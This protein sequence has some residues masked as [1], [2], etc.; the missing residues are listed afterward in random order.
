MATKIKNFKTQKNE[1][2]N[3][4]RDI[5]AALKAIGEKYDVT[6]L[7]GNASYNDDMVQFKLTCTTKGENGEVE[8]KEAKDFK[9]YASMYGLKPEMLGKEFQY[10]RDRFQI[11]G[12]KPRSQKC[13][14]VKMVGTDK[15]YKFEPEAVNQL[16][17]K[18]VT[19]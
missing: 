16:M 19:A 7:A 4:R 12:L 5:N 15:S 9:L 18:T 3:I 2:E 13:V 1:I 14:I 6:I 17:S 11:T 8:T 10:G